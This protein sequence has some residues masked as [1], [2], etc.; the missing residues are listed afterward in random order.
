MIPV[1]GVVASLVFEVEDFVRLV[2]VVY[3]TI[4]IY[5]QLFAKKTVKMV[6]NVFHQIDANASK[7]SQEILVIK[8]SS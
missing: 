1:Y 4:C 5:F 8:V 2:R 3:H 6:V 7:A